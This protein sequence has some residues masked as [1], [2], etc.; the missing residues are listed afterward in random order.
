MAITIAIIAALA[1]C[2]SEI[3]AETFFK[4]FTCTL[5]SASRGWKTKALALCV[6]NRMKVFSDLKC[7]RTR[8]NPTGL[9]F[10]AGEDIATVR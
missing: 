1:H 9:F 6:V 5:F 7:R 2:Y 3:T 8:S 4:M 10:R